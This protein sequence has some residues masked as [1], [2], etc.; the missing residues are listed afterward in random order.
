MQ[1]LSTAYAHMKYDLFMLAAPEREQKTSF[2]QP[3]PQKEPK[4]VIKNVPEGNIAFI[5]FPEKNMNKADEDRLVH[6]AQKLRQ[7]KRYNLIVGVS[8]WGAD[9]ERDFLERRGE[10]FDILLGAGPGPG[11][12]G[13]YLRDNRVLWVRPFTQGKNV[14]A[15][16]FPKLPKPGEK[17]VWVPDT[18]VMVT[19]YPLSADYIPDPEVDALFAP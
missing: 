14:L 3:Y 17:V 8:S 16:T 6:F 5:L 4:L 15:V 12:S 19:S 7:A 1:A 10:A 13:E 11:Y 2:T 9:R 18:S